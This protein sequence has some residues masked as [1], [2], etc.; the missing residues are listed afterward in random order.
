MAA[1]LDH[2]GAIDVLVNNGG[3][4]HR[5]LV[6]D[7][8]PG[9]LKRIIDVDFTG[10]AALTAAVLPHMLVRRSGQIVVTS[11]LAGKPVP[12]DKLDNFTGQVANGNT[13]H[14]EGS[15]DSVPTL[16]TWPL[17]YNVGRDPGEAYNVAKQHPDVAHAL[18]ERLR[19]W[20]AEYYAN[21]KGWK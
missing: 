8:R 2:F 13:Y 18:E 4:S 16:G 19:A 15:T 9:V 14:P 21:P 7:T 5:S 6:K 11:S 10:H 3:I 20:S 12:L 17:L 1:V